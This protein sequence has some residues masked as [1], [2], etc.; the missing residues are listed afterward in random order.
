MT[1]KEFERLEKARDIKGKIETCDGIIEDINAGDLLLD[2]V[3]LSSNFKGSGY[4]VI[5]TKSLNELE[6][7]Y[8][9]LKEF[10]LEFLQRKRD[11]LQRQF[12]EL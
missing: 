6:G 9:E 1:E 4:G 8:G 3:S 10:I 5:G 11:Y 7:F 12:D 2:G